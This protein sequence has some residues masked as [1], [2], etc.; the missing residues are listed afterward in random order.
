[1]HIG[2][3][4]AGHVGGTLAKH[5]VSAGHDVAVANSRGPQTLR[6]LVGDLGANGHAATPAEAARYG[7]VVV[8]SVPFNRY[9]EVPA[10]ELAGKPVIDTNNY[11]PARDGHYP[12][13]DED[14][15]TSGELLQQH[16]PG[17]RVVKAFNTITWQHLRDYGH[18]GGA[19]ML[20][21]IPV[22]GD[23]DG[24]KRVVFDLIEEMGFEPVEAGGLAEGGRKHQ[25]G[26]PGYAELPADELH[27]RLS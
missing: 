16:L 26:R 21:G 15:T 23:D 6:D 20:Y 24:A 12:E 5:F 27:A 9:R 19:N 22:S 17:A 2:I 25:P 4:G 8:V 3:I 18:T 7:E 13:L 1:M 14:R 11:Y 10:E